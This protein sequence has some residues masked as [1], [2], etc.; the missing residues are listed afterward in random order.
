MSEVNHTSIKLLFLKSDNQALDL[1]INFPYNRFYKTE[2]KLIPE[3]YSVAE[4][5]A[6]QLGDCSGDKD[7]TFMTLRVCISPKNIYF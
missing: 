3:I 1:S 7:N 5:M 6:A 4:F 2:G